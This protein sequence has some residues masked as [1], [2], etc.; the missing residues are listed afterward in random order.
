MW[1]SLR[2]API[3]YYC[4]VTKHC[5]PE[6]KY[7]LVDNTFE[8]HKAEIVTSLEPIEEQVGIVNKALEKLNQQSAKVDE[9]R[10][11]TS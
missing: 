6:H 1:G 8:Q 10:G 9:Q 3:I 4:T 2:L 11:T 5:H 7:S